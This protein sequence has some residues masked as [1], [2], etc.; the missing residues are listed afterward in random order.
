AFPLDHKSSGPRGPRGDDGR[1][2]DAGARDRAPGGRRNP[3]RDPCADHA[4]RPPGPKGGRR[5]RRMEK[6]TPRRI[7]GSR[8]T[9][10]CWE[11]ASA[12][13]GRRGV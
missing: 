4:R 3:G 8:R 7:S 5:E 9:R 10:R 13:V 11:R 12:R 1:G 2:R 6:P